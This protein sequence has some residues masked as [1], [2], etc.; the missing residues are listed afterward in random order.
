MSDVQ[1]PRFE[2]TLTDKY[3]NTV[4]AAVRKALHLSKRDKIAYVIRGGRVT[5]EKAEPQDDQVDPA[6]QAFLGFLEREMVNNPQR[7]KPFGG[8]TSRRAAELVEGM[9]VDLDAPLDDE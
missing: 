6:V 4:P 5:L 8:A 3:Q 1:A 9:D 7:L 2:A